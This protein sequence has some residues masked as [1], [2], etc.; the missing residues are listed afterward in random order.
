MEIL[1]ALDLR[2]VH[3]SKIILNDNKHDTTQTFLKVLDLTTSVESCILCSN[4]AIYI[5]VPPPLYLAIIIIILLNKFDM[6]IGN[7]K[8]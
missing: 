7:L 3:I 1:N 6:E 8:S 5:H 2:F 4:S